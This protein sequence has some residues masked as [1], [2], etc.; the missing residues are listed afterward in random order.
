MVL[1]ELLDHLQDLFLL[2]LLEM[3][4]LTEHFLNKGKLRDLVIMSLLVHVVK[5]DLLAELVLV[6]VSTLVFVH[7]VRKFTRLI[8]GEDDAD[9]GLQTNDDFIGVH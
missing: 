1:I 5:R 8:F 2:P 4:P 7:V 6:N 9:Y 3:V